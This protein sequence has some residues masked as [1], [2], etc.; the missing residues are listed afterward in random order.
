MKKTNIA[1]FVASCGLA[2]SLFSGEQ[3]GATGTNPPSVAIR[4]GGGGGHE[5]Q[6]RGPENRGLENRPVAPYAR[7]RAAARAWEDNAAGGYD[8]ENTY[9]VP[10]YNDNN[11]DDNEGDPIR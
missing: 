7:D 11:D 6:R 10:P 8:D 1:F 3:T 4:G 5:M 9:L 2:A